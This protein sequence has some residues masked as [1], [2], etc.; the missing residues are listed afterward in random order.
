MG[1]LPPAGLCVWP[2][3]QAALNPSPDTAQGV[4]HDPEG[5]CGHDTPENAPSENPGKYRG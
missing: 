1:R 4:I 5:T 3:L 2:S